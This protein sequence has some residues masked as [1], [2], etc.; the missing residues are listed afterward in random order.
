MIPVSVIIPTR[1]RAD[2]LR[3]TIATFAAQNVQ[4]SE[5]LIIDGSDGDETLQVCSANFVT[6][7]TPIRYI[8]ARSLGAAVQR[9]QGVEE[10]K[11]PFILFADD[12]VYL[13]PYCIERLWNAISKDPKI[14]GVNAM[15]VNQKYLPMGRISTFVATVINGKREP[16]F[17]GKCLLPAW[18]MLPED[19][20]DLP[21]VVPVEWLNLTTT[22]YRREALPSPVFSSHFT[23]YS[24]G[25]DLGLSVIVSRNWKLANARTARIYHDSQ[26]GTHK[27][28]AFRVAEMDVV[29]RY[30]IMT[31]IMN[32]RGPVAA[33]KLFFFQMFQVL[34][35]LRSSEGIFKTPASIAG[36]LV[37]FIKICFK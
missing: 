35:G 28:S 10:A 23:G 29:N 33:L 30:Y 4:A 2:V 36:R 8:R 34:S 22:I 26:P 17:A 24:L 1:N 3:K 16:S 27:K 5:M 12:D 6:L 11:L 18:G 25:E 13:E 31:T 7:A 20:D 9:N 19:S 21:E 37:G 15:I 32:K 14:G